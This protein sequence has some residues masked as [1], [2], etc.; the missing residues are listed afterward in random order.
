MDP[1]Q[2]SL[3]IKATALNFTW[4]YVTEVQGNQRLF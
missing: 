2:P 4:P 1:T 3:A